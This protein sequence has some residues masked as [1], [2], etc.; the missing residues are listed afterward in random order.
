MSAD[1]DNLCSTTVP[2]GPSGLIQA[3]AEVHVLKPQGS[4]PLIKTANGHVRVT[5]YQQASARYLQHGLVHG[6][7]KVRLLDAHC[8]WVPGPHTVDEAQVQCKEP[9]RWKA[10]HG[11]TNL[12]ATVAGYHTR[13][14]GGGPTHFNQRDQ[15]IKGSWLYS[16]VRIKEK[17]VV[18]GSAAGSAATLWAVPST[19]PLSTTT[20]SHPG[21]LARSES[22][23]ELMWWSEL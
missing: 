17:Q 6:V 19:D 15:P 2:H 5:T 8:Q 20:T 18:N 22:R 4:E 10:P 14:C 13:P 12:E 11:E 9:P 1:V 7:I 21:A 3:P 23:Q 16:Y